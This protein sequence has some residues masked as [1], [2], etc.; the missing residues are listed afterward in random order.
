VRVDDRARE[1]AAQIMRS[2]LRLLPGATMLPLN[3]VTTGLLPATLR[4]QY[5]LRWGSFEQRSYRL[6]VAVVPKVIA[7][8]PAVLRVWPLPGRSLVFTPSGRATTTS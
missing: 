5:G 8:T 3:V 7:L 4:E 6:A 1:L 2:P